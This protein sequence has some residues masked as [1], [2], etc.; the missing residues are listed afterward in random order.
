MPQLLQI[1]AT[2]PPKGLTRQH[3]LAMTEA[4]FHSALVKA[5]NKY[6]QP[7]SCVRSGHSYVAQELE[8]VWQGIKRESHCQTAE[9]AFEAIAVMFLWA[10]DCLV[11]SKSKEEGSQV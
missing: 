1:Q 5:L 9:E 4:K 10:A 2:P 8:D 11:L 7:F 3:R 6:P